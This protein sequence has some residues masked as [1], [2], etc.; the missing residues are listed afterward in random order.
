MEWHDILMTPK[1]AKWITETETNIFNVLEG[2]VRSG[3][4]TIMI[5]AF[6]RSLE[7]VAYNGVHIAFAESIALSRMI[8]LEGGNGLGIKNYF[9]E[10]ARE[11]MYKGKDALFIKI[12]N[13]EQIVIFVGSKKS[14]S[15]KSIRGLTITSVIGTEISLAHRSF[16]EETVARTLST[17]IAYRRLF[18]DTNP[19]MDSHFIYV[20]FIDRWVKE[21]LDGRML[22]G[23]NYDTA[24]LYENPSLTIEQANMIASQYDINSP[25]YKALIL[26]MRINAVDSIYKLYEYSLFKEHPPILEYVITVDIGISASATTFISL[27]KCVDG[28]YYISSSYYHRNGPQTNVGAKE[29]EEYA[30][31][32]IE[33]YQNRKKILNNYARY[34]FIDKDISMLRILTR[35]F[36]DNKIPSSKLNYVIKEKIE[37]RITSVRNLL[38]TG[39]LMIQEDLDDVIRA[40]NN[41]V[42]DQDAK[43]KGKLV[44]LDDTKLKFN[45]VDILDSIEYAVSY[46]LKYNNK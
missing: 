9:G 44:R 7:R 28:K 22:G 12:R 18:Y 13:Y 43:D 1:Y 29:Y 10:N 41:A 3:K 15:Y 2:G 4:T 11:G 6:C 46:F 16:M 26:G 21:S 19:T 30:D 34:V 37:E 14:D 32:L 33:Y 38:Y 24:S 5:L 35:K 40:F 31:D 23:V 42:Y 45:P 17:P 27:V 39:Q 25:F 36:K 20:D 8:L